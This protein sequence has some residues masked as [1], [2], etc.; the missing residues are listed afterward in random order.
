MPRER[1]N[2]AKLRDTSGENDGHAP[3]TKASMDTRTLAPAAPTRRKPSTARF[4]R[5]VTIRFDADEVAGLDRVADSGRLGRRATR[6]D[7]VRAAVRAYL[8][9]SDNT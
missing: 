9:A 5:S 7:V 8:E 4:G 2:V 1:P 3:T 6:S